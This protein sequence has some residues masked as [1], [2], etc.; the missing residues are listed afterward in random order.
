MRS[1]EEL[2]VKLRIKKNQYKNALPTQS[3]LDLLSNIWNAPQNFLSRINTN[4]HLFSVL[5]LH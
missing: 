3:D 2:R 1:E 5:I 4:K